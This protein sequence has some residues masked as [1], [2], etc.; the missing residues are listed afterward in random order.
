MWYLVCVLAH[1]RAWIRR[2]FSTIALHWK[3]RIKMW[4]GDTKKKRLKRQRVSRISGKCVFVRVF[5][6]CIYYATWFISYTLCTG[7]SLIMCS[8]I[9]I[10]KRNFSRKDRQIN[11]MKLWFFFCA[12]YEQ[13]NAHIRKRFY[14]HIIWTNIE[15]DEKY[16]TIDASAPMQIKWS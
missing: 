15:C 13:I 12:L 16:V 14:I 4:M 7:V 8:L 9:E 1:R 5:T 2:I 11:Y 3:D 6:R 10:W